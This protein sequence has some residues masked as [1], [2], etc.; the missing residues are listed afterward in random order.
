LIAER[1]RER[2]ADFS[3]LRA[4]DWRARLRACLVFA[5]VLT[6]PVL[7]LPAARAVHARGGQPAAGSLRSHKL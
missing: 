5:I 6:C 2:W 1:T 7:R 4:F 3:A